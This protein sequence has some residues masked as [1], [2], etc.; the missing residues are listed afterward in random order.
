MISYSPKP[1]CLIIACNNI[2]NGNQVH[3]DIWNFHRCS[4][5]VK[6]NFFNVLPV[7]LLVKLFTESAIKLVL[8]SAM[9]SELQLS[10]FSKKK[11]Y[12]NST[13]NG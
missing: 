2:V 1:N 7:F 6:K 3:K 13:K 10:P 8:Q 4:E 5:K 12:E 11:I 9:F